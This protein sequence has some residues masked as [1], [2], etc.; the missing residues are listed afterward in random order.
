HRRGELDSVPTTSNGAR[1][2]AGRIWPDTGSVP[3]MARAR[4]ESF[5]VVVAVL[6]AATGLDDPARCATRWL[7]LSACLS[8]RVSLAQ[9]TRGDTG[10][11]LRAR[12]WRTRAVA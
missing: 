6:V 5:S 10:R 12:P 7:S 3:R 9:T 4:R 11:P 2:G 8:S 1:T